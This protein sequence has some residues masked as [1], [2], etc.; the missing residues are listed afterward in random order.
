MLALP[1]LGQEIVMVRKPAGQAGHSGRVTFIT[2]I[3]TNGQLA[4]PRV[5]V[6]HKV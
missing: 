5:H 6:I 4:A 1:F 3:S 2:R